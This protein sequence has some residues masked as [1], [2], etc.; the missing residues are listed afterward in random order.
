MFGLKSSILL[1]IYTVYIAFSF[2][3]VIF[4]PQTPDSLRHTHSFDFVY[5]NKT[6]SDSFRVHVFII[7]K[8]AD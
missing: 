2:K 7:R 8:C 6:Y 4:D 3:I 5:N 1:D